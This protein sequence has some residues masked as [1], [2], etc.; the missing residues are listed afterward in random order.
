M[1]FFRSRF[2][3]KVHDYHIYSGNGGCMC[4][5]ANHRVN[6]MLFGQMKLIL[7]NKIHKLELLRSATDH[8]SMHSTHKKRIQIAN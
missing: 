6:R 3:L 7:I 8:I 4:A 1:N 2:N 5:K